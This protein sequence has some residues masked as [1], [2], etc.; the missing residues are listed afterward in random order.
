MTLPFFRIYSTLFYR[1]LMPV[2][3]ACSPPFG[4]LMAQEPG[5]DSSARKQISLEEVLI[6]GAA[7]EKPSDL[8]QTFTAGQET[9]ALDSTLL[10]LYSSRSLRDLLM[11]QSPVF[12][13]SFGVN[14]MATLSF[15]GAS[16]AQSAVRW[17]GVP[18]LNPTLGVT[19]ISVLQTGLFDEVGLQYGSSAALFG[20]GNVGGA[21]IL[22]Q[23]A[24][25][26][27]D[28]RHFESALSL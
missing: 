18:V 17:N 2:I 16:A 5:G 26:F 1:L 3:L 24:P 20:S 6:R 14:S 9:K 8:R 27:A 13:K 28:H 23:S 7:P 11:E 22:A 19:D 15:R 25:E 12:V 10:G 21:L 4:A